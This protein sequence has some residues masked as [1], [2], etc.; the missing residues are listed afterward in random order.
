MNLPAAV[1]DPI[2]QLLGWLAWLVMLV[3]IGRVV[4]IGGAL[5]V[6]A[7]RDEAVE[8]FAGSLVGAVLVGS[9]SGVAGA[10]LTR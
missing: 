4:W 2:T 10:V 6:R 3:C 9:A 5:A 1:L 7:Y 8:G